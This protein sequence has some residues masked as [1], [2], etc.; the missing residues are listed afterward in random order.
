[1]ELNLAT[2]LIRRENR[3]RRKTARVWVTKKEWKTG[4]GQ[5]EH[6]LVNGHKY[7]KMCESVLMIRLCVTTAEWFLMPQHFTH[8]SFRERPRENI[9]IGDGFHINKI[10][11]RKQSSIYL[12]MYMYLY[13]SIV[14]LS[15]HLPIYELSV[16]SSLCLSI[17]PFIYLSIKPSGILLN[18]DYKF[19]SPSPI[20][21][22]FQVLPH[23]HYSL[24]LH[25]NNSTQNNI[26]WPFI[27]LF[28][29]PNQ[30]SIHPSIHRP[31]PNK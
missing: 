15:I 4:E 28:D 18:I 5:K 30:P 16:S 31:E 3:S 1:M 6:I 14:C 11:Q 9:S 19:V 23:T 8:T 17:Y 22:V 10:G 21:T 13:P 20:P 12:C 7:G 26:L 24:F 29:P 2:G 25:K 27:I